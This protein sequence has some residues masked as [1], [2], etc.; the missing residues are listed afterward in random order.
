MTSTHGIGRVASVG[1]RRPEI[2]CVTVATAPSTAQP[3]EVSEIISTW[4]WLRE[5]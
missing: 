1:T 5:S 3:D 4:S 2:R